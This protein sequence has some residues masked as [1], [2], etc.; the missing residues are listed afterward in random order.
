MTIDPEIFEFIAEKAKP[1]SFGKVTIFLS[2]EQPFI[3]VLV[4]D[5]TRHRKQFRR[6][7]G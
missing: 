2:E 3:D 6:Q 5:R 7:N 4:E 1:I